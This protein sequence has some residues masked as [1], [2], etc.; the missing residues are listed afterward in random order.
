ARAFSWLYKWTIKNI[1]LFCM[2][3]EDD[4]RRIIALGADPASVFVTGNC[5]ADVA[6][7]RVSPEERLA[8]YKSFFGRDKG[9]SLLFVAGSTNP[10]EDLPVINA[11]LEARKQVPSLR[12]LIA[13]R[14]TGRGGEVLRMLEEKGVACCRR[15]APSGEPV[16]A[17]VLDTM[18]E[19]ADAYFAGDVSFVGGSLIKKGCHSLLQ[20]VAAGIGV[21]YGPY[22]FKT[23]DIAVQTKTFGVGFE[24]RNSRELADTL[25]RILTEPSLREQIAEGCRQ[26]MEYNK[27]AAER[28]CRKLLELYDASVSR[29]PA[30][31]R[32]LK[33]E[34]VLSG[35][36][37]TLRAGLYRAFTY[38]LSLLYRLAHYLYLLPYET[39][40]R[41]KYRAPVPVIS[42]GNITMGGT[43]KTP[44]T[45]FLVGELGK[46]GLKCC[47]LSRGYGRKNDENVMI[48]PG[49]SPDPEVC[50]DEPVLLSALCGVPVAVGRDRRQTAR[51]AV[52]RFRPDI[53][54]MD[55]GMQFWQMHR[56]A[57]I[58]LVKS[59]RPFSGGMTVPAGDLR[60]SSCGFRRGT[61]MLS[62]GSEPMSEEDRRKIGRIAPDLKI[63]GCRTVPSALEF[64][65]G[66]TEDVSLLKG[67]KVFAFC[68][69]AKPSRFPE[70]LERLGARV[71]GFRFFMDHYKYA[72]AD[73]SGIRQ[74]AAGCDLVVTTQKDIARIPGGYDAVPGVCTLNITVD[75]PDKEEIL[76]LIMKET[77]RE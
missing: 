11:W 35:E 51:A 39:G 5:K 74:A 46:R 48:E 63:Y 70:T 33:A 69:I 49:S 20:P 4:K 57:E 45:A 56:D 43:G 22:T 19:L 1:D 52:E 44:V 12:L 34:A 13:P 2:Q 36:S 37:R 3:S 68:G 24:I 42:V 62:L 64:A 71:E 58:I 41:K 32:R 9:D 77:K 47:I 10:G 29:C 65:G 67:R 50:G 30:S 59:Q 23:K 14:Q 8:L 31:E 55:D 16:D 27:G 75:I 53:L 54:I 73:L 38:P 66:R 6:A 7:A 21:C 60:E 61:L 15:T 28:T 25:V 26:M 40:V 17:L 18:G 72:P 76:D